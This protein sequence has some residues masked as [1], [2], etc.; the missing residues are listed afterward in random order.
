MPEGTALSNLDKVEHVVVLM[1]E[2][3][4]F[5]H[6]LGYL[7]LEIGRADVD[8]LRARDVESTRR[9]DVPRPAPEGDEARARS[10]PVPLADVRRRA[11][12][13]RERRLRRQLRPH[14]SPRP[15]SRARDGLLQGRGSAGL[16]LPRARVLASAT[17]GSLRFPGPPGPIASTPRPVAQAGAP[18]RAYPCMTYRL[19]C[20]TSIAAGSPGAGTTTT[21]PRC[22][23]ST[24]AIAT[25]VASASTFGC[26][27]AGAFLDAASSRLPPP[28]TCPPFPGSTRTT[29][30]STSALRRRTT[31]TRRQT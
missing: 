24:P 18:R 3:R 7:A 13:G 28:E 12:E 14:P 20:A 2:N 25:S 15:H 6:M 9:Q 22:R 19:S 30:T 1:M 4:S 26:S 31:T 29:S 27:T 16:R 8:G 10:G 23:R 5:A 17:A 21:F 11:V